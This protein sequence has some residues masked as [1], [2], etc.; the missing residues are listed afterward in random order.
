[1]DLVKEIW[2]NLVRTLKKEYDA[3]NPGSDVVFQKQNVFRNKW[4]KDNC[5]MHG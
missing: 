1:M 5:I 4:E 3:I 2:Q